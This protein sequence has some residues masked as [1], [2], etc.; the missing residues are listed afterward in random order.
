MAP[1]D[2]PMSIRE[3]IRLC[4]TDHVLGKD[5]QSIQIDLGSGVILAISNTKGSTHMTANKVK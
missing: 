5:G 4:K 2:R 3:V 1:K